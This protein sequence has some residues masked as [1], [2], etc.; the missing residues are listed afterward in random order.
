MCEKIWN[1]LKCVY[2]QKITIPYYKDV[3][4]KE[5]QNKEYC[6]CMQMNT[7]L[8]LAPGNLLLDSRNIITAVTML[9]SDAHH[10]PSPG[11]NSAMQ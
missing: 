7:P 11:L 9:K 3:T 1:C 10:H 6:T 2:Y 5:H 8:A 4:G